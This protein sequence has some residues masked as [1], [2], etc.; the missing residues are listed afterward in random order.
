MP[1]HAVQTNRGRD[2]VAGGAAL[3]LVQE[4]DRIAHRRP[5]DYLNFETESFS[6]RVE[7]Q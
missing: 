1:L 6:N 5:N 2:R 4:V 3:K 7:V